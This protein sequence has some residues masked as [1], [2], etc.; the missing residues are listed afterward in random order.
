MPVSAEAGGSGG[1]FRGTP[2]ALENVLAST[3]ILALETRYDGIADA[4]WIPNEGFGFGASA[5]DSRTGPVTLGL[6]YRWSRRADLAL[7]PGEGPGWQ[8]PGADEENQADTHALAAGL[9]L[10]DPNRRFAVGISGLRWF[11]FAALGNDGEGWRLG[12]SLAGRPHDT[13]TLSAAASLPLATSGALGGEDLPWVEGGVRWQ[14]LDA[15]A[16]LADALLPLPARAPEIAVGSEWIAGDLV[17]LRAG[18]SR[19]AG[20]ESD[21]A[22]AGIGLLYDPLELAYAVRV[23][24]R[25]PGGPLHLVSIRLR[26]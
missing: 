6:R 18:W 7:G 1:A 2:N 5:V 15:L 4:I 9:A 8:V 19:S 23:D 17:P 25:D 16:F 11:R 10:A 24:V 21:H 14:P 12:G 26:L 3:A 20:W 13:V 22:T